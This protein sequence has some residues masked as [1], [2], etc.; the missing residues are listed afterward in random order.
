MDRL[1][2]IEQLTPGRIFC[3][4]DRTTIFQVIY[5]NEGL[6]RVEF[7]PS[8]SQTFIPVEELIAAGY[9]AVQFAPVRFPCIPSKAFMPKDNE[10]GTEPTH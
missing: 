5:V 7:S 1:T 9:I 2:Q 3:N 6:V 4:Q 10:H 8:K